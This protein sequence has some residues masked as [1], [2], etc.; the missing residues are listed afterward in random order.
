MEGTVVFY[1]VCSEADATVEVFSLESGP[2]AIQLES[3]VSQFQLKYKR[4]KPYK[5]TKM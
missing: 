5:T 1:G 4:L 3:S 2:E